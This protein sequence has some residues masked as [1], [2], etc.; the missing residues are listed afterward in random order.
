MM[1][2]WSLRMTTTWRQRKRCRLCWSLCS[3]DEEETTTFERCCWW[4]WSKVNNDV[5][6]PTLTLKFITTST[7]L[8]TTMKRNFYEMLDNVD[9]DD[10]AMMM[11]TQQLNHIDEHSILCS[12]TVT[13]IR[14]VDKQ[15][16]WREDESS[17][18]VYDN[19]QTTRWRDDDDDMKTYEMTVVI[20]TRTME[21]QRRLL[22]RCCR[23]DAST[24][25]IIPTMT[26]LTLTTW[27]W[28]KLWN[29]YQIK[30]VKCTRVMIRQSHVHSQ[31]PTHTLIK[32]TIRQLHPMFT[33]TTTLY[34]QFYSHILA[35]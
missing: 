3:D 15:L 24:S 6:A 26:T 30:I 28:H 9:D 33:S 21:Q 32:K 27:W 7:A 14:R 35:V 23:H 34:K 2:T 29:N 8:S 12:E 13:I 18:D 11:T 4:R 1:R 5:I 16:R 25:T 17:T 22:L 31:S 19:V 20:T 10:D